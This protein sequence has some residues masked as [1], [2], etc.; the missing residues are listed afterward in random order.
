MS[1]QPTE[2]QVLPVL[3]IKLML[4]FLA[5]LLLRAAMSRAMARR[6]ES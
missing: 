5:I 4:V 3:F 6:K 2:G 1:D